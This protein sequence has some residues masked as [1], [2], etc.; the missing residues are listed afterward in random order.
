LIHY[1]SNKPLGGAAIT[2]YGSGSDSVHGVKSDAAGHFR[3]DGIEP[4][5]VFSPQISI[6][7]AGWA[8]QVISMD[9]ISS[10]PLTVRMTEKGHHL[11][12]RVVDKDH[13]PIANARVYAGGRGLPN[14][15]GGVKSTDAQ[16]RFAFDSLPAKLR[17]EVTADGFSGFGTWSFEMDGPDVEIVLLK[18]GEVTGHVID[19]DTGT[20]LTKFNIKLRQSA[21][22]KY[23]DPEPVLESSLGERGEDFS[24]P[25]GAF[26][27]SPVTA[28]AALTL[29]VTAD[30]YPV[31]FLDD[32]NPMPTG[33]QK[34]L[35]IRLSRKPPD[36]LHIAGKVVD[37]EG[38]PMPG[39]EMRAIVYTA[40]ADKEFLPR[41]MFDFSMLKSGQLAIQS[42]V[43][44]VVAARTAMDGTFIFPDLT[45]EHVDLAYWGAGVPQTRLDI[46]NTP[47]ADRAN[48]TLRIPASTTITGRL[49]R[50]VFPG[51]SH[52]TLVSASDSSWQL[53][54]PV[55]AGAD[56]YEIHDIPA[57]S[58]KLFVCGDAIHNN[59]DSTFWFPFI[60]MAPFTA[61]GGATR[62][63]DFGTGGFA[64]RGRILSGGKP[65][66]KA[67]VALLMDKEPTEVA[68]VSVTDDQG[69]FDFQ[70]VVPGK[71]TIGLVDE[72]RS[73]FLREKLAQAH[74]VEVK[75]KDLED[76]F[77]K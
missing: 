10:K 71:Y 68:R 64:V 38:K 26:R 12:G 9:S 67:K 32:I 23:N 17:F 20:P 62:I 4:S 14:R 6:R 27:F 24:S 29:V 42:P 61:A 55:E 54:V 69:Q 56:H 65:L 60:A 1:T 13:Q 74:T 66:S 44:A 28:G 25:T 76:D 45:G 39:V 47:A 11:A 3:L 22:A 33:D 70:Q 72:V 40:V 53:E 46:S 5:G 15:T 41:Y 50:T 18:E 37:A 59:A 35:E 7:A 48:L 31:Q 51:I 58:Y 21:L 43:H 16:G 19:Q 77:G 49:N 2:Y 52:L 8:P 75:D 36:L 63:V 57:G 34:P 30:G 73:D